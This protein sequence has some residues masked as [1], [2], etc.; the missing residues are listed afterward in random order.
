V[1]TSWTERHLV[2]DAFWNY[3][4]EGLQDLSVAVVGVLAPL[5]ALSADPVARGEFERLLGEA[6]SAVAARDNARRAAVR[7]QLL[8]SPTLNAEAAADGLDFYAA[9][10]L[11]CVLYAVMVGGNPD[12]L[13]SMSSCVDM[14]FDTL[15]LDTLELVGVATAD[16]GASRELLRALQLWP[17]HDRAG[18]LAQ[19]TSMVAVTAQRLRTPT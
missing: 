3:P 16:A 15:E 9:R 17:G 10:G 4:V 7:Q 8:D 18:A 19:V 2:L 12:A 1:V 11:M 6:R 13:G 5:V 14:V